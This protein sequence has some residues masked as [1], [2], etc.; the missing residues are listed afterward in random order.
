MAAR[1]AQ[2][3][4]DHKRTIKIVVAVVILAVAVWIIAGQVFGPS[5][6]EIRPIGTS[7]DAATDPGT[8]TTKSANATG[9]PPGR[10]GAGV[11]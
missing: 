11:K 2:S 6:G 5:T 9:L 1:S 8:A 10:G 3:G 4:G 7:A